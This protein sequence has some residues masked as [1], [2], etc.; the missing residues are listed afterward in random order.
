MNQRLLSVAVALGLIGLGGAIGFHTAKTRANFRAD[1]LGANSAYV[2]LEQIHHGN[3]RRAVEVAESQLVW[4]LVS[5]STYPRWARW[6]GNS[7]SGNHVSEDQI[8]EYLEPAKINQLATRVG[9][10]ESEL[11][12]FVKDLYRQK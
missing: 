3:N 12:A 2:L 6:N 10:T 7:D 8:L 5:V 4:N 11:R 1:L 9:M